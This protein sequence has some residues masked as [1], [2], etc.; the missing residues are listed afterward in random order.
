MNSSEIKILTLF[1][2]S[3]AALQITGCQ[4]FRQLVQSVLTTHVSVNHV[5]GILTTAIE[6]TRSVLFTFKHTT[7]AETAL[8]VINDE[9]LRLS[10]KLSLFYTN[11]RYT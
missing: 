1:R 3:R 7:T 5:S 10:L 6:A 8:I 4:T 11:Q 9:E 2:A